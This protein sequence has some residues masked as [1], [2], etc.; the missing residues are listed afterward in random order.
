[1]VFGQ[2]YIRPSPLDQRHVSTESTHACSHPRWTCDS[3]VKHEAI[4][5]EIP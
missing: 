3:G 2:C 1:M 5:T 4:V